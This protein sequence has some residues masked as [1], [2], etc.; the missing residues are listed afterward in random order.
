MQLPPSNQPERKERGHSPPTWLL[1]FLMFLA[2]WR[3]TQPQ[4]HPETQTLQL[5]VKS[6]RLLIIVAAIVAA[7]LI[8]A[9]VVAA[10]RV[11]LVP[12]LLEQFPFVR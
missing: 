6:I 5:V 7:V 10:G 11:D 4:P 2:Y 9:I 3:V 8:V 1:Y 12:E